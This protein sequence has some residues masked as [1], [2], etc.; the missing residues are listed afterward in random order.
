MSAHDPIVNISQ[1]K[2]KEVHQAEVGGFVDIFF[3]KLYIIYW[4]VAIFVNW[5]LTA[6][7]QKSRH[8]EYSVWNVK[9]N[10]FSVFK[11]TACNSLSQ[12]RVN[13][14]RPDPCILKVIPQTLTCIDDYQI[15]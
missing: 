2:H 7:W 15:T 6:H 10:L 13:I 1:A 11:E 9:V 14:Y 3:G 8:V 5:K 12:Y 4:I